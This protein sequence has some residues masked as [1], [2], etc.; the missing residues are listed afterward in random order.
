[1]R[2]YFGIGV[3]GISKLHNVGAVLRSAH[4]FGASFAF[5]VAP[6]ADLRQLDQ[7]DTSQAI[8]QVPFYAVPTID[9]L[10]LPAGCRLVGIELMDE[11]IDLPSFRHPP[12]A[13]YILGGERVGLTPE[14]LARCDFVVKIPM[15]FSLN[16]SVAGALVMY[17]RLLTYGKFAPRPVR[18]GGPVEPPPVH[19]HG[20]PVFRRRRGG[21]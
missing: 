17:D 10:S 7:A 15:R 13:A 16:L 3:E 21:E 18:P 19:I 5:A 8:D 11:S 1:M 9:D 20:T 12:Q 6:A 14:T 2:G 4:A